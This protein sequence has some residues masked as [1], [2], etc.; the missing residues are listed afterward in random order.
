MTIQ[1]GDKVPAIG[2]QVM[3]SEGPKPLSSEELFAGKKVAFSRCQAPLPQAV[4]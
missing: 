1:V 3:T 4:Q 2:F